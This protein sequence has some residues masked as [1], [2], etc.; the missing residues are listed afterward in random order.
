LLIRLSVQLSDTA[1]SNSK[2][3]EKWF[4]KVDETLQ[5]LGLEVSLQKTKF[6]VFS[7]N[8]RNFHKRQ[9]RKREK[10]ETTAVSLK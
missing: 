2:D 9:R 4:N 10:S 8:N 1:G 5:N 7:P 6:M 3:T